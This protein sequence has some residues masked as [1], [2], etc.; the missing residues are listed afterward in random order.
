MWI[1]MMC[2]RGYTRSD[3][4]LEWD[5][6]IRVPRFKTVT[7]VAVPVLREDLL[8]YPLLGSLFIFDILVYMFGTHRCDVWGVEEE[9]S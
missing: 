1:S 4:R 5:S 8:M 6:H 2:A 7:P 9:F 3:P